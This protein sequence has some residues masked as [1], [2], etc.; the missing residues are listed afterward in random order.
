MLK[1][2]EILKYHFE[3]RLVIDPERIYLNP[4]WTLEKRTGAR[5]EGDRKGNYMECCIKL[6]QDYEVNL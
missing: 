4:G 6:L 3:S 1:K 2:S 5:G